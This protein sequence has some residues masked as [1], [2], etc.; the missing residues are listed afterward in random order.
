VRRQVAAAIDVVVHLAREADGRRRV[1]DVAD[2]CA[3]DDHVSLRS[4]T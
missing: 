3:D 1:S 4:V 2:V